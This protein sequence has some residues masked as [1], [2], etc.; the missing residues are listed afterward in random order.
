MKQEKRDI[1]GDKKSDSPLKTGG[2]LIIRSVK[3]YD[4]PIE[5]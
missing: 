5:T 4:S 1:K 3:V 2:V